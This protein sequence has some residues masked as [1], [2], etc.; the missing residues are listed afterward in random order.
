MK[1]EITW[2]PCAERLPDD[3]VRV[4][5]VH[6]CDIYV[7][8]YDSS[9]YGDEGGWVSDDGMPLEYEVTHWAHLP[10]VPT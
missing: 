9:A 3:D 8:W 2:I 7:G 4:L 1:T 5:I 6:E 10:E